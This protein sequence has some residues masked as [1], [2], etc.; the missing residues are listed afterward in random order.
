M[1]RIS[2]AAAALSLFVI[3]GLGACNGNDD[4]LSGADGGACSTCAD[5]Y[6]NGGIVCGPS[7]SSDAWRT[8]A[9]CACGTGICNPSCVASFCASMPADENCGTCLVASCAAQVAGCAQN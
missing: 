9:D 8:L 5:I 6:T 1:I 7:A 4:D 2:L 3:V